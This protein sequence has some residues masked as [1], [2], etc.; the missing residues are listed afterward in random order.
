MS[1][2]YIP[3]SLQEQRIACEDCGAVF[4]GSGA[5]RRHRIKQH[6]DSSETR[7]GPKFDPIKHSVAGTG[8]CSECGAVFSTTFFLRRHVELSTCP[9]VELLLRVEE[10][11]PI[12][13]QT[14][15]NA[16]V[17]LREAAKRD[18]EESARRP[19]FHSAF[20]ES[21]ILCGQAVSAQK[22]IKQ[23]L[24]KQH[25]GLM[26]AVED[27]LP[28]RLHPFKVMMHKGDQCR[29][30]HLRIDA[31]GRHAQQCAP[32]LQSHIAQEA[33]R[34]KLDLRPRDYVPKARN[35]PDKGGTQT[36]QPTSSIG[37]SSSSFRLQ[38]FL[39]LGNTRNHCYANAV[40]QCVY[41]ISAH[42]REHMLRE[43]TR[44]SQ[45]VR[46]TPEHS[47]L[48]TV[49]SGWHFDGGQHDAAEFL[50]R[51]SRNLA[52][53]FQNS[54]ETR[55]EVPEGVI[56]DEEGSLPIHIDVP[57]QDSLQQIICSW[58]RQEH[59]HALLPSPDVVCVSL[60]RFTGGEKDLR[61]IQLE[62][63]VSVPF[64]HSSTPE[65]TWEEY[66]LEALIIHQGPSADSGH[67]R[68]A[69]RAGDEWYLGDDAMAPSA[70]ALN[71]S[72]L[73][74]GSYLLFLKQVRAAPP[75]IVVE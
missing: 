5:L 28:A 44:V 43:A 35:K 50:L 74:T 41:W 75:V 19:E 65:V 2:E 37:T 56:V 3:T 39:L 9:R 71:D 55:K 52:P 70:C 27:K 6:P 23:H 51:M 15:Q 61:A 20:M 14:Q 24:H 12:E 49:T 1:A 54:W 38:G 48:S 64:F 53:H 67:Y 40:L 42:V 66:S 47:A 36:S 34:M 7:K 10:E 21:C 58:A 4:Q 62:P 17:K 68:A 30:C 33:D 60:P 59:T 31:P 18:P 22:G 72:L 25:P 26:Q 73:T 11:L 13:V 57:L 29:Y 69:V 32:L 63:S 45:L 46:I 8:N 16:I